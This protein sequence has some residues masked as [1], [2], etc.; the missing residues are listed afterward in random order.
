MTTQDAP[1]PDRR[2]GIAAHAVELYYRPLHDGPRF[3]LRLDGV[4]V[5]RVATESDAQDLVRR[6]R[7]SPASDVLGVP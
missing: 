2:D 3:E 1:Q 7:N 5:C 6:L 4:V